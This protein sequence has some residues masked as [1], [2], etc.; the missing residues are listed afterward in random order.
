VV[1]ATPFCAEYTG[2]S[3]V[4]T[5]ADSV[6]AAQETCVHISEYVIE[7]FELNIEEDI[8]GVNCDQSGAAS[9][10]PPQICY[11]LEVTLE[12]G[13]TSTP[14]TGDLDILIAVSLQDPTVQGLYDRLTAL[15]TSNPYST[16]TSVVQSEGPLSLSIV[17][18]IGQNPTLSS[19]LVLLGVFA[20]ILF[21][22][23]YGHSRLPTKDKYQSREIRNDPWSM[24]D[25]DCHVLFSIDENGEEETFARM[26]P[27]KD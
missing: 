19:S 15:P 27:F 10:D 23:C 22:R 25:R 17:A 3:G 5:E 16:T 20:A 4:G 2:A 1:T 7:S 8:T 14:S 18:L 11:D 26:V 13:L 9:G 24:L 6:A 21:H 12:P